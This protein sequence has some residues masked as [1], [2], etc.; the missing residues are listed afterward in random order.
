MDDHVEPL[1]RQRLDGRRVPEIAADEPVG[2]VRQMRRDVLFLDRRIVERVE[3]VE[4]GY[5][6]PVGEQGINEVAADE[7][8]APGHKRVRHRSNDLIG[9]GRAPQPSLRSATGSYAVT[10]LTRSEARIGLTT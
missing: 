3:V 9:R 8:G 4:T 5:P 2:R 10:M 7:P 6:P 1:R